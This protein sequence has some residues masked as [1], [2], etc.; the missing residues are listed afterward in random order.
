MQDLDRKHQEELEVYTVQLEVISG[1]GLPSKDIGGLSDPYVK[2]SIEGQTEQ[3]KVKKNDLN[4]EWGEKF[5]WRFFKN[6]K[7]IKFEVLDKDMTSDDYIGSAVFNLDEQFS[8][9][10]P[11]PFVGHLKLKGKGKGNKKDKENKYG[12]LKVKIAAQRFLPVS[13]EKQRMQNE[14]MISKQSQEIDSLSEQNEKTRKENEAL[15]TYQQQQA[16]QAQQRQQQ[17]TAPQQQQQ[18]GGELRFPQKPTRRKEM[19][20]KSEGLL[21]RCLC[22]LMAIWQLILT[23]CVYGFPRLGYYADLLVLFFGSVLRLEVGYNVFAGATSSKR[24]PTKRLKL[25]EYEGSIECKMVREALCALDLDC[26]IYPCP[27]PGADAYLSRYRG[28]VKQRGCTSF[29]VLVDENYETHTVLM[30][31]RTIIGY[32]YEE[33]GNNVKKSMLEKVR[34]YVANHWLAVAVYRYLYLGLLRNLPEQGN[35]RYPDTV[36]PNQLLELWSYEASPFC[37]KVREVLSSLEIPYVLRNVAVGSKEKRQEFQ[38]K[39]GKKYPKWRQKLHLI[40]VPL[41]IDPNTEKEIF[42]SE[43][44]KQYLLKTYRA[45][46]SQ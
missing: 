23:K 31:A 4:P 41:L 42:E 8:S 9:S 16:K 13:L 20:R 40:Q 6:P 26:E 29:P 10:H 39:F 33:Y 11:K 3:T 7:E 46:K 32:L 19:M 21:M 34:Y 2:V 36:K 1:H 43:K 12:T 25:Y 17:E 30:N 38:I 37:I 35:Q 45:P 27:R 24:P 22:Q 15:R 28:E 14:E 44:I 18:P 5:E